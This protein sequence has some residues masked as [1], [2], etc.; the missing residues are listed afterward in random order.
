MYLFNYKCSATL[1]PTKIIYTKYFYTGTNLFN[2]VCTL[3][4]QELLFKLQLVTN[5][6][7]SSRE[8]CVYSFSLGLTEQMNLYIVIFHKV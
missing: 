8:I 5:V 1:G 2:N 6:A 3:S 4:C 7:D